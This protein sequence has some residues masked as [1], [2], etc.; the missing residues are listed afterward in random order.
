MQI[1]VGERA[2]SLRVRFA[3]ALVSAAPVSQLMDVRNRVT[4][5]P[6]DCGSDAEPTW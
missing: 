2:D 6:G 4:M 1:K 5:G 3:C